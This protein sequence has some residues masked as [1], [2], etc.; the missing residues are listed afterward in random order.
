MLA[1]SMTD[2][3]MVRDHEMYEPWDASSMDLP[4][5]WQYSPGGGGVANEW[6]LLQ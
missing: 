6:L 3:G 4:L 5:T 1:G 2:P